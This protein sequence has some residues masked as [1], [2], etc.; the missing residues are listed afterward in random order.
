MPEHQKAVFADFDRMVAHM[1]RTHGLHQDEIALLMASWFNAQPNCLRINFHP[2]HEGTPPTHGEMV[3]GV[4]IQGPEH[5]A[6]FCWRD[7]RSGE[8]YDRDGDVT[9]V[10]DYWID[11][12]SETDYAEK[13][14][15]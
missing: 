15:F 11:D 4:W 14:S 7:P 12:P 10:P 2:W 9:C 1:A 6:G 13:R 8:W 3:I 5:Y